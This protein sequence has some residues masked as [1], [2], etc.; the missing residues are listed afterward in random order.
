M[1]ASLSSGGPG[2]PKKKDVSSLISDLLGGGAKGTSGG[3][4][5]GGG[6]LPQ[7]KATGS[8][9]FVPTKGQQG[10]G[11]AGTVVNTADANPDMRY[12]IDNMKQRF[13]GDA[14][15]GHAIDLM[16]GKLRDAAEGER[17]VA[18]AGRVAR[19]VSGTG[20]DDFDAGRIGDKLQ[21]NI[22]G[23]ATDI[24][25][26][27]ERDKDSIL[28]GIAGAGAT[29]AGIAGSAQ[30]RALAQWEAEQQQQM[31]QEQAQLSKIS[32]ILAMADRL[33]LS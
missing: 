13:Q 26:G 5:G 29:A 16:T 7:H 1:F 33:N 25:L 15:A 24:A 4:W 30:D 3:P 28:S 17:R 27:R 19:G 8:G 6:S 10:A 2:S 32:A 9:P 31:A 22:A 11:K 23:S 18:Q 14:G 20:V 21:R 12:A